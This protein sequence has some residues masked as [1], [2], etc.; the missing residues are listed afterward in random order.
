MAVDAP[1]REP[2][3]TE[4]RKVDWMPIAGVAI[5]VGALG[6]GLYLIFKKERYAVG[7]V[8]VASYS[9]KYKGPAADYI[10]QVA[11]GHSGIFGFDDVEGTKQQTTFTASSSTDFVKATKTMEYTVPSLAKDVYDAE[12]SI[13]TLDDK[14]I[15]RY[16]TK[17]LVEVKE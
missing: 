6:V 11:L 8:L 17:A 5:G 2:P 4:F 3:P 1:L 16:I 10:F 12:A 7:D 14:L 15:I 13:R 9:Y